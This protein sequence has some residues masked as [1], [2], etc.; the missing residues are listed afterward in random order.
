MEHLNLDGIFWLDASPED[1]VAGRLTFD[2]ENGAD[3]DLLGSFHTLPQLFDDLVH[4]VRIH[5]LAGAKRFTLIECRRNNASMQV[6]GF[7]RERYRPEVVLSG[8]HFS[9]SQPLQFDG[10]RLK[11]SHLDNW[12]RKTG[13]D[14]SF[15]R[16]EQGTGV[17]NIQITHVPLDK[18][19]I[20]TDFGELQLIFS[21][22][23][24]PDPFHTTKLTQSALLGVEFS[25]SQD[26][27]RVFDMSSDLMNLITVGVGAPAFVTEASL[28]NS[29]ITRD[30]PSGKTFPVSFGL[31]YKGFADNLKREEKPVHPSQMLFTF[32]DIGGLDGIARWLS[33]AARFKAV[34]GSLLSHW[35]LP[36]IYTENQF[37]NIIIATEAFERIRLNRQNFDFSDGLKRLV[38]YAG[39]PFRSMVTDIDSWVNEIIR[40]RIN[41]LV[42][43]GLHSEPDGIRIYWLSESLYFLAVLCLLRECGIPES[44]M[45]NIKDNERLRTI[46]ERLTSTKSNI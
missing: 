16:D 43:R 15:T 12:V 19:V 45:K 35:Y 11:L 10:I 27:Q 41:Y 6:P 20:P 23:F 28:T 39:D 3:L 44:V 1:K 37:L 5:G 4:P 36:T 7:T 34:T 40:V 42:H 2:A 25:E 22:R 13:T 9:E 38:N 21:Y 29:D 18:Q 32:D 8:G 26:L 24:N 31:Y 17:R 14:I 33:T 46:T 30:L